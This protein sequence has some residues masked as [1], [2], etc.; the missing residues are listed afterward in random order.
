M[1]DGQS[2]VKPPF[3]RPYVSAIVTCFNE[4]ANIGGCIES[5]S[6]CDEVIVVDSY[7]TDRTAEIARSHAKVRL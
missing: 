2:L 1:S 4:E 6:W 3:G 7:S 5:L